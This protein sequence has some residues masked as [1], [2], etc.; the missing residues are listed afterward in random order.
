MEGEQTVRETHETLRWDTG[1]SPD[2]LSVLIVKP[3]NLSM[4]GLYTYATYLGEQG[5]TAAQYWLAFW[6]RA[7]MPLRTAV[8]VLVASSLVFCPLRPVTMAFRAVTG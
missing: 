7:L 8:M 5:L 6:E 3:E 1:L 2:V 4:S